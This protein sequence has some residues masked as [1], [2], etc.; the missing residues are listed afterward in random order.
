MLCEITGRKR[1]DSNARSA[2][3]SALLSMVCEDATFAWCFATASES[4]PEACSICE[5]NSISSDSTFF[6]F[7][8]S[9]TVVY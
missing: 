7:I 1:G 3:R 6:F 9:S 4:M 8:F 5:T 2:V